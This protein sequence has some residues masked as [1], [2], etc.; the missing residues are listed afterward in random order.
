VVIAD[1]AIDYPSVLEADCL[2]ALS[3]PGYDKYGSEVR[4]GSTVL[5]DED[6]VAANDHP[7]A[8]S[9]HRLPFTRTADELGKRIV[10]NIVMLGSLCA[11][12]RVVEAKSLL[13]AVEASVPAKFRELNARA[14][15]RGL[16]LGGGGVGS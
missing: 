16:E 15:Q 10:A 12:T 8:G 5:V 6:M 13:A 1:E 14:F 3:Q 4:E 11:L 9:F 2:V 7:A